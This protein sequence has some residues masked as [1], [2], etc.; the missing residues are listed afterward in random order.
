MHQSGD[1][2]S[3]KWITLPHYAQES[4]DYNHFLS[5][6]TTSSLCIYNNA[7]KTYQIV[8]PCPI[9]DIW[10]T[11]YGMVLERM[12]NSSSPV[13]EEKPSLLSLSHPLEELKPLLKR[14]AS[15][16]ACQSLSFFY[17]SNHKVVHSNAASPI[18]VTY[19]SI[20]QL[21]YIW[22]LDF[23]DREPKYKKSANHKQS[24]SA[25]ETS[26][27]SSSSSSS[28]SHFMESY[29]SGAPDTSYVVD[30]DEEFV[31]D[32][33]IV[34]TLLMTSECIGKSTSASISTLVL[35]Q[36]DNL[37]AVCLQIDDSLFKLGHNN[38]TDHR[39]IRV[40]NDNHKCMAIYVQPKDLPSIVKVIDPVF[41]RLTLVL[42]D[43]THRRVKLILPSFE[44]TLVNDCLNI[45]TCQDV[46][47]RQFIATIH[48]AMNVSNHS[49]C[50]DS[51]TQF[52]QAV[53]STLIGNQVKSTQSI[54]SSDTTDDWDFVKSWQSV[55]NQVATNGPTCKSIIDNNARNQ[56][57]FTINIVE[58]LLEPLH[59]LYEEYKST[60][61]QMANSRALAPLL[62]QLGIYAQEPRYVEY[63]YRENIEMFTNSIDSIQIFLTSC[64][65]STRHHRSV[66]S[67]YQFLMSYFNAPTLDPMPFRLTQSGLLSASSTLKWLNRI[68][69]LFTSTLKSME[70][71]K[72]CECLVLTMTNLGITNEDINSLVLGVSTPLREAIRYCRQ[73]PPTNWPN[74]AYILVGRQDLVHHSIMPSTSY[75]SLESLLQAQIPTCT[76]YNTNLSSNDN[77]VTSLRFDTDLRLIEVKRM[78]SFSNRVHINHNQEQ[79]VNDHDYLMELQAK[80]LLCSQRTMALTLGYGMFFI[81]ST[82]PLPTEPIHI[83]PIILGGIVSESK[84]NI[85]LN[86]QVMINTPDMLHWPEF[87]TGVAAGLSLTAERAEITNT[88]I[89]YN[90]PSEFTPSYSGLLLALGLQGKLSSLAFT[91][92]FE[93]LSLK[94]QTTSVGL[95]LGI[96]ATKKGTMEMSVAKILSIHIPSLHPPS[97]IDLD[98]PSYVQIASVMGIGLLYLGTGNRRMTEVLLLEIGCKPNNDKHLDRES[99]SLTAGLALGLVNL[100]RGHDDGTLEDLSIENRLKAYINNNN[101]SLHRG[102]DNQQRGSSNNKSNLIHEGT[103]PNTDITEPGAILALALIYL[104]SNNQKVA[105]YYTLPE[106]NYS[107]N[108]V[109]TN[110]LLIRTLG[111][112][113]ILWD[114]VQPT[115]DWIL[116]QVPVSIRSLVTLLNSPNDQRVFSL[117]DTGYKNDIDHEFIL[118]IFC[119][120]VAGACMSIGMRFAGT[121]NEQASSVLT[122]WT[123]RFLKRQLFI[124]CKLKQNNCSRTMITTIETCLGVACLSLSLVLSGTGD[125]SAL[126]LLRSV[127]GRLSKDISYGN[128]MAISMS[129]GFLFLGGGRYT[130]SCSNVAIAALVCA[131]YPRF[132][133]SSTDNIYHL[134]ALRHFYYLAIE[135]RC[136]ITRDIDTNAPCHVPIEVDVSVAP[137]SIKTI[138]M[139]TPC[140][141][142]EP[143][144]IHSIRLCSPRYWNLNFSG[145]GNSSNNDT[146]PATMSQH[147]TIFVKRKIGHLTYNEDPEGFKSLAKSFP[148]S[149]KGSNKEDILKS[150]SADAHILSFA[151]HYCHSSGTANQEDEDEANFN[152][153]MLYECLTH[154]QPEILS[155][156]QLLHRLSKDIDQFS[157]T[158]TLLFEQVRLLVAYHHYLDSIGLGQRSYRRLIDPAELSLLDNK[159]DNYCQRLSSPLTTANQQQPDLKRSLS[160]LSYYDIHS[161]K[162]WRSGEDPINS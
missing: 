111:K 62:L 149:V 107:F 154:D 9:I 35:E 102:G 105:S 113:L 68:L 2:I 98:V 85:S 153:H 130:L 15:V 118:L 18:M 93:Y 41:N 92:V 48:H 67:V 80:L 65:E 61:Y 134:Q 114:S 88:W 54:S 161:N 55:Q 97:S 60:T 14:D 71:K 151:R 58:H 7:G 129:I 99:Y 123:Q 95:L 33:D 73:T 127:R 120:I 100:G 59:H 77:D 158:S 44:S 75:I 40:M 29:E 51:F 106:S 11:P 141:L 69:R 74:C 46:D 64:S 17:D 133:N 1:I 84:T 96:A 108:F 124:T 78:L 90:R 5:I 135:P 72:Q 79:G 47:N 89:V 45:L 146:T 52:E 12:H 32:S 157:T 36:T 63:Y 136:L 21:H 126:R 117:S 143:R 125:L 116:N 86:D 31:I 155:V 13:N 121:A 103:Y 70:F 138:S 34:A 104:K 82:R 27:L 42:S 25:M 4:K 76:R 87:H 37:F 10:P 101:T 159:I 144:L 132:P 66:P 49:S 119:N 140:L 28:L 20:D 3:I 16:I 137:D 38:N 8:P 148:K 110:C 147:P 81:G 139:I 131:L 160:M 83:P 39:T 128:H 19:H 109:R 24:S 152:T 150:F 57:T 56:Y 53:L 115:E 122:V 142:P 6:L 30:D 145:W 23:K 50:S 162:F 91:K 22:R 112:S 43:G 94:N 156:Q 26:S